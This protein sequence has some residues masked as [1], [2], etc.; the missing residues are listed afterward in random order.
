[1]SLMLNSSRYHRSL[2]RV[3]GGLSGNKRGQACRFVTALLRPPRA[4][5]DCTAVIELGGGLNQYSRDDGK[6][7]ENSARLSNLGVL[8]CN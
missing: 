1:M 2:N 7:R 8:F 4:W 6:P 5:L 3:R